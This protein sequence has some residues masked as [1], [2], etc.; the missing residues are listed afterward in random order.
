MRTPR[1]TQ[2][3][4]EQWFIRTAP[5]HLAL[6]QVAR[7]RAK[8]HP[9]RLPQLIK[10]DHL[11]VQVNF[12][13][14]DCF[15]L[16]RRAAGQAHEAQHLSELRQGVPEDCEVFL[17]GELAVMLSACRQFCAGEWVHRGNFELVS[18]GE[19]LANSAE[20]VPAQPRGPQLRLSGDERDQV[21]GPDLAERPGAVCLLESP[22]PPQSER[23]PFSAHL[24]HLS[25][26]EI[27][28]NYAA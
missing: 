5:E 21:L 9:P 18:D 2:G 1:P 13:H 27:P 20:Y 22:Q 4:L 15:R 23:F 8:V 10:Y 19:R 11:P 24:A 6:D 28:V 26:D 3:I 14:D 12:A 16:A 25:A 7:F 17:F